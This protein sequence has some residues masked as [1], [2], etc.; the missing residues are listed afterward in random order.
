[1]DRAE[2]RA[3][4]A[5]RKVFF[6]CFC[7][8]PFI[9][10]TPLLVLTAHACDND[11]QTEPRSPFTHTTNAGAGNPQGSNVSTRS[12]IENLYREKSAEMTLV[13]QSQR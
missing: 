6:C 13:N 3:S 1:M 7:R 12:R 10:S 5:V 11:F 9:L 8:R 2:F 4:S